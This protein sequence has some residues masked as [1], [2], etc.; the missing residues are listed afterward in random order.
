MRNMRS[1]KSSSRDYHSLA[2]QGCWTIKCIIT[3]RTISMRAGLALLQFDWSKAG[4]GM[5]LHTKTTFKFLSR[6]G[7][8]RLASQARSVLQDL[9]LNIL[10]Y[11]KQTRLINSKYSAFFICVKDNFKSRNHNEQ[12]TSLWFSGN[13]DRPSSGVLVLI[14]LSTSVHPS[15][16]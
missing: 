6:Q 1:Q 10:L 2:W 11:E 8:H 13:H 7:G 4:L 5:D 3:W 16:T 9:G 14:I 12:G 15:V